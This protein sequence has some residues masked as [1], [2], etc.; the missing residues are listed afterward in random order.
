MIG[1]AEGQ[2]KEEAGG[3]SEETEEVSDK[4]G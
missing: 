2:A 3:E 4:R 1:V